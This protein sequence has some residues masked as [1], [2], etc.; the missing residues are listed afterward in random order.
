MVPTRYGTIMD[1]DA[2]F[3]FRMARDVVEN[4]YYPTW[5]NLGW[6][7]GGRPLTAEMPL[8]PFAIA[9][10]FMLLKFIGAK[11]SLN[12]W[13]ILF[14][15]LVGSLSV[16]P[17]YFIGKDLR[18]KTTGLIA[19]LLIA[20][21]PEFL[22]R[23]MGGVADKECLAFPI[24]LIGFAVMV[25]L[26]KES[27]LRKSLLK[28]L[29]AGFFL[30]L[31]A[32]TWG[33]FTFVLLLITVL[34]ALAILLDM[35]GL[36]D[37]H[38]STIVGLIVMSASMLLISM[39]I[40]NWRI[41]NPFVLIHTLTTVGLVGYFALTRIAVSMGVLSRRVALIAFIALAGL[42]ALFPVYGSAL[43]LIEF[44][45]ASKF[46]ILL[47]PFESPEV[48]M[49]I[50]VQ[51]YAKPTISDWLSRYSFYPFLALAGAFFAARRRR[52]EDLLIVL[53]AGS[54]F[55]AGQSAIRSTMLLTPAL[56]ILS[57]IAVREFMLLLTRD[58]SLRVLLSSKSKRAIKELGMELRLAKIGA[59][60]IV[61][62]LLLL[63]V[64]SI[65]LGIQLVQ[66]RGPVLGQ[67]WYDALTWLNRETPED[68]I[69][70]AWWDYGHWITS[71]AKRR[72]V[73]DGAT[74]NFST[75]QATAFAY[76]SPEDVAVDIFKR[77]DVEYVIV[78]EHDFWL[79]GAFAQIVGNVTDFPDGYYEFN[80]ESGT[81]SWTD[82]TP[83]GQN[84]TIYKLLFSQPDPEAKNFELIHQSPGSSAYRD[85]TVRIYKTNYPESR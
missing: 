7:P 38:D 66:G 15:A 21:I 29:V 30:G 81:I 65:L 35:L 80:Q 9:Y 27:D 45:V 3:M 25:K 28:G 2:F 8:L 18:D 73:S 68:S 20:T 31:V 58:R 57:A 76:L 40:P 43:G 34:Y 56:C 32:L 52:L 69:I 74:T 83:K 44:K 41:Q 53:W 11:I 70:I 63:M 48:G 49:H 51:E 61:V 84:T 85:T 54:G 50:T 47:N 19:A 33:G 37:V 72:C 39:G 62:A 75:I 36:I 77:Y 59:P 60:L 67:G 23:T 10:T 79:A 42:A 14:P 5:D 46:I 12:S 16:I 82:L 13:T 6:Q 24:V 78:P 64:P 4:G 22:N 26:L 71:V 55:Y 1:P 17:I